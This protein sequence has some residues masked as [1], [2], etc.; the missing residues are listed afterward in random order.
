MTSPLIIPHAGGAHCQQ[1]SALQSLHLFAVY[2]E[3]IL[4]VFHS[5]FRRMK[6]RARAQGG[7]KCS[8]FQDLRNVSLVLCQLGPA[9]RN[10]QRC[11]K[12]LS[13]LVALP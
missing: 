10:C 2:I 3:S 11:L 12:S 13:H 9:L 8:K 6:I 4:N 1:E 7:K 5:R